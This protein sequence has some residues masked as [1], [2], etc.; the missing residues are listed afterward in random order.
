MKLQGVIR[1]GALTIAAALATVASASTI[2]FNTN[3]AGTQ[4]GSGVLVLNSSSGAAATL[5]FTPN[6]SATVGVPSNIDL[7]DFLLVCST[8]GPAGTG[9]NAT[10]GSFT[11]DLVVTD[12]TDGATGVF[13]GTSTGGT[14]NSNASTISIS[15]LPL[16]LGPGTSN[17]SSGSFGPTYFTIST[18]TLIVA[19]N[20]G[21]P[22]G[23]T[24]VQGTVNSTT[25]PEP[26]TLAMV[27]GAFVALAAL[28]RK[29]RK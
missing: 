13:V 9:P 22:Q 4:F 7:G 15:W 10:F 25:V 27:G 21:S 3:A 8:C 29:R 23:D 16:Q 18:P 11:F 5:T 17:A 6:S 2:T 19:P 1:L 24:T 20:S 12:T 28:S 26:A 14:V